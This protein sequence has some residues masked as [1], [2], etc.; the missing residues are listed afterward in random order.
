MILAIAGCI[1]LFGGCSKDQSDNNGE[2][3][4]GNHQKKDT[5]TFTEYL[6]ENGDAPLLFLSAYQVDKNTKVNSI[7]V[8]Q[9]G[10]VK[11]YSNYGSKTLGD[12]AQMDDAEILTYLESE[13]EKEFCAF[14]QKFIDDTAWPARFR[15]GEA[16]IYVKGATEPV[17]ELI[18]D[19]TGNHVDSEI[20]YFP[21]ENI[22]SL[23]STVWYKNHMW[24]KTTDY[25]FA[26]SSSISNMTNS[27]CFGEDSKLY[28]IYSSQYIGL[29]PA[30]DG[31]G[32]SSYL[33]TRSSDDITIT[34]DKLDP[35]VL[36]DLDYKEREE[37]AR[38]FYEQYKKNYQTFDEVSKRFTSLKLPESVETLRIGYREFDDFCYVDAEG[39]LTGYDIELMQ[40]LCDEL[41]IATEFVQ[42]SSL[43][44]AEEELNKGSIDCVIGGLLEEE[45][46]DFYVL[47]SMR[48]YYFDSFTF[49]NCGF[50]F[51]KD[52]AGLDL[53][54]QASEKFGK[55]GTVGSLMNKYGHA[56]AAD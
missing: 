34:M 20:V 14:V 36:T 18:T 26:N 16:K 41:G 28:E 56:Y 52:L 12:Y 21:C 42:F 6:R 55:D 11:T 13:W 49:Q 54:S 30:P 47:D 2:T 37:L 23:D 22:S 27:Y 45:I 44:L 19:E 50:A 48:A 35:S 43:E 1:A 39:K 4:L 17:I 40:K 10:K 33:L 29:A 46:S 3:G 51:R 24:D 9:N 31:E 32:L 38:S 15:S 8:Y 7:Y 53:F 5:Y 25:D